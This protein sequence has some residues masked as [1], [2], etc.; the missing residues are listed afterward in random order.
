MSACDDEHIRSKRERKEG[1]N[2][3]NIT[4]LKTS[5]YCKELKK[6]EKLVPRYFWR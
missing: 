4:K 6:L 3:S 5:F 2:K 1:S